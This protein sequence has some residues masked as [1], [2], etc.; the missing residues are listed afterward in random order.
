MEKKLQEIS[1][2]LEIVNILK[3]TWKIIFKLECYLHARPSYGTSGK[4]QEDSKGYGVEEARSLK[5]LPCK[6]EDL[7]SPEVLHLKGQHGSARV[8][9]VQPRQREISGCSLTS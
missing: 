4:H 6:S 8:I 9:P 2:Y 5:L 3:E 7:R 1:W